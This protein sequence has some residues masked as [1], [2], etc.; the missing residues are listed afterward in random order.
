MPE[1]LNRGFRLLLYVRG[2]TMLSRRVKQQINSAIT[3]LDMNLSNNY[4]DLAHDAL[5]EL[6]RLTDSLYEHGEIKDKDYRKLRSKV[7]E[8]KTKMKGYHH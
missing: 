7:D 8:Y 5:K 6:D 2:D 4:K 3:E 1:S